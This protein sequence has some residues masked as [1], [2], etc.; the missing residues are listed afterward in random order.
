MHKINI[1]T[2]STIVFIFTSC[3]NAFDGKNGINTYYYENSKKIKQ[4]V[5]FKDGKRHGELKEY[6]RNGILKVRQYYKNDTLNDSSFFY[7][8]NGNLSYFQYLKNFEKE[9]TWKKYNKQGKVYEEINFKDDYKE[10]KH[11]IYTYKTLKLL[12]SYN[13]SNGMKEGEQKLFYNNGNPKA[14]LYYHYDKPCLGTI[15]WSENGDK[16]DN[17]FKISYREQNN[18]LLGE[19]LTY[20][21]KLENPTPDDEVLVITDIKDNKYIYGYPLT[22]KNG[23]FILEYYVPKGSFILKT[24]RLAA[25]RK[26]KMGN[27]HIKCINI[28]ASANNY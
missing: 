27:T 19:K 10:G 22:L 15:E 11:N 18:L 3:S 16:I 28:S 21:I 7:H 4:T 24:E 23:E 8:E 20:Y 14:V 25:F 5:E 26:T 1:Y 12:E 6:Y 2:L 9:G 17:D 13:Y